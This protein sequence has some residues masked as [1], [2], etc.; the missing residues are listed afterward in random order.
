MTSVSER[1][2]TMTAGLPRRLPLRLVASTLARTVV[3]A[4][5]LLVQSSRR[6][7]APSMLKSA[8]PVEGEIDAASVAV[9]PT[10]LLLRML[11]PDVGGT[12]LPSPKRFAAFN[13]GI[14]AG[15]PPAGA[16]PKL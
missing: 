2:W 6:H 10:E 4:G 8:L 12:P 16:P 14:G 5:V 3:A 13:A 15:T 1:P 9:P 7:T 11:M